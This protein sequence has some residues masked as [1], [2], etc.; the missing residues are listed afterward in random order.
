MVVDSIY[1]KRRSG[2]GKNRIIAAL[3]SVDVISLILIFAFV[4][5]FGSPPGKVIFQKRKEM[6]SREVNVYLPYSFALPLL[7]SEFQRMAR[8]WGFEIIDA[9]EKG[10]RQVVVKLGAHK[11]E[12]RTVNLIRDARLTPA[13]LKLVVLVTGLG[14]FDSTLIFDLAQIPYE[15]TFGIVPGCKFSNICFDLAAEK[16]KPIVICLPLGMDLPGESSYKNYAIFSDLPE[17]EIRKRVKSVLGHFSNATGISLFP[18][19]SILSDKR[20]M[21]TVFDEVKNGGLNLIIPENVFYDLSYDKKD[22]AGVK[23]LKAIEIKE[24]SHTPSSIISSK[25]IRTILD[26][27]NNNTIIISIGL[28]KESLE[29]LKDALSVLSRWNVKVVSLEKDIAKEE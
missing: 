19:S 4:K 7:N 6:G 17:K 24:S 29:A 13:Q 1:K 16:K 28:S 20:I 23:V 5:S 26:N 21:S 18:S 8:R 10:S 25:I 27:R 12:I 22:F 14:S 2:A 9:F 3:A 15:I 11:R